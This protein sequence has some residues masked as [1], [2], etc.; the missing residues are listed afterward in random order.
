MAGAPPHVASGTPP[1]Q[2]HTPQP[3]VPTPNFVPSSSATVAPP[4]K[5]PPIPN[6]ALKQENPELKKGQ[7]LKYLEANYAPVRLPSLLPKLR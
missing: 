1:V 3:P 4:T 5:P 2:G 6:P 7:I